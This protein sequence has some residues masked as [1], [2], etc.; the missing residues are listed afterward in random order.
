MSIKFN[1]GRTRWGST[2]VPTLGEVLMQEMPD[3][4]FRTIVGD[5]VTPVDDLPPLMPYDLHERV[6]RL[7]KELDD[8]KA[9]LP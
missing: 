9:R 1:M 5:G 8:L 4:S 7:E 6:R 3:G 2:Y